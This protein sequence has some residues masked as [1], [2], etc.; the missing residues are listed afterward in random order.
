MKIAPVDF[1]IAALLPG[2]AIL[3]ATGRN[4]AEKCLRDVN[5]LACSVALKED[6]NGRTRYND[7]IDW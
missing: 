1:R 3:I 4:P 5:S 6:F 2:N 7:Q